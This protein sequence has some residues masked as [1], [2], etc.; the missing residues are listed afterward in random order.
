[1]GTD[2]KG[3]KGLERA[4]KGW[5]G[6]ERAGKGVSLYLLMRI[7]SKTRLHFKLLYF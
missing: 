2:V 5:K 4:G 6:L 3:W 7:N 1:M